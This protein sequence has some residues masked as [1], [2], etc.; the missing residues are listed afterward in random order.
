MKKEKLIKKYNID[1]SLLNSLEEKYNYYLN[2]ELILR[3]KDYP[4]HRGSN[5]YLHSF[6]VCKK[7]V[8]DALTSGS[9]VNYFN[10]LEAAVLHDYYL[11]NWRDDK[12]LLKHHASRHPRVANI[13][14]IKDFNVNKEVSELI[15]THMWP[16]NFKRYP[17]NMDAYFVIESDKRVAIVEAMTSIRYKK[18]R[19]DKYYKIIS[20]LFD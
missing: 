18:K 13:N 2:H 17:K 15:L 6:K 9:K 1:E 14:A 8:T 16:S 5:C 3:M 7:A 11:Y 19:T 20:K 10:I 4:M 12:D